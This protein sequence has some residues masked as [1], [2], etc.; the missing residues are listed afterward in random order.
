MRDNE[1]HF[2]LSIDPRI[3]HFTVACLK[4]FTAVLVIWAVM[5]FALNN[6]SW[7]SYENVDKYDDG[8]SL[9][10]GVRLIMAVVGTIWTYVS[11]HDH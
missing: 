6:V 4:G 1:V 8:E 3:K 10:S 11:F 7:M 2:T 5:A 9:V